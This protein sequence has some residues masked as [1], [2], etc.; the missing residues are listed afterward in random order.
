MIRKIARLSFTIGVMAVTWLSLTPLGAL[1]EVHM[2]DKLQHFVAYAVLAICG[3][4]G[5]PGRRPRLLVGVGLIVLGCGLEVAQA[6]VPGRNPSIGDA[7][8][9]IAG[10][11][12]GLATAWIGVRLVGAR[13]GGKQ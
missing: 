10:I 5:F 11:A 8:A 6:A 1:P 12:F 9:N 3:V 2:W 13:E 4:V 7:V